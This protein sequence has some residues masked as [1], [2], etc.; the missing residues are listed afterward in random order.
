MRR[1]SLRLAAIDRIAD[2]AETIAEVSDRAVDAFA[3]SARE[4]E[5]G[6]VILA[7]DVERMDFDAR[8]V[9]GNRRVNLEHVSAEDGFMALAQVERVV[10]HEDRAVIVCHDL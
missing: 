2:E 5:A 3:I 4:D 6:R 9:A 10:F 1:L 7:A 8:L